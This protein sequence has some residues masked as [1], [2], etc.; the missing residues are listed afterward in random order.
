MLETINKYVP[1][2]LAVLLAAV[3]AFSGVVSVLAMEGSSEPESG[4]SAGTK[5]TNASGTCGDGLS[6][7][8]SAGTLTISGSGKMTDFSEERMAPWYG[9][10]DEIIR[11]NLPSGLSTIGDLAFYQCK[12]LNAVS[13]PSSVTEIGDNSFAFCEGMQILNLG[14]GIVKIGRAA[15]SDCYLISS[16]SLPGTLQ[17]LGAKAFYRCETI[18]TVTVP[19]SVTKMGASVFS[20]CKNLVSA[21]INANISELPEY[22]FYGCEKLSTVK[23]P[24]TVSKINDFSFENC[25]NLT[26]VYY[27]GENIESKEIESNIGGEISISNGAPSG[28]VSSGSIEEKEDGM[29]LA[30]SSTVKESEKSIISTNGKAEYEVERD[31]DGAITHAIT[32]S[33]S[34]ELSIVVKDESGWTEVIEE[35]KKL[36]DENGTNDDGSEKHID[37]S[38]YLFEGVTINDAFL[39]A[40][41]G[42]D[43]TVTVMTAD[44]SVWKINGKD[45]DLASLS[46]NYNL[47][48]IIEEAS[49]EI[50][51]KLGAD[52]AF[53]LRFLESAEVNAEVLIRI[54]TSYGRQTATLFQRN[55]KEYGRLQSVVVDNNGYAHFYLGSVN[56]ETEYYI[57][58]NLPDASEEAIIPENMLGDY[59]N[60]EYTE[61]IQYEITGRTSSWGMNLGQV[62]GILGIVM[63]AVI[64]LVGGIMFMW[65]KAK[66]KNGYIPK[67]EDDEE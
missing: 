52:K 63:A 33:S 12:N 26:T 10:C 13:I 8:F 51:E 11:L 45:I 1:R 59:G 42:K 4:V 31:E 60:P 65:N 50:C 66:L 46:G 37:I 9:F 30:E 20:Y 62:M 22:T 57:A 64:I 17:S 19:A 24:D 53:A 48:Y 3:L 47:S 54:G 27:D 5:T 35:T 58:M 67:F 23:L 61:P 15:F 38:L 49:P 36:L 41:A 29:I 39:E 34:I 25:D 21:T 2:L 40:I 28:T 14:S 6:W 43:V 55:K 32:K 18:T 7:N 16:I 44:G 56:E